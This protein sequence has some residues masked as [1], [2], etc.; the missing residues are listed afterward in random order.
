MLQSGFI[1]F[2]A[3]MIHIPTFE[4]CCSVPFEVISVDSNTLELRNLHFHWFITVTEQESSILDEI[5]IGDKLIIN[6]GTPK[7]LLN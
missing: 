7:H 2:I 4:E 6:G 1:H 5:R 3:I